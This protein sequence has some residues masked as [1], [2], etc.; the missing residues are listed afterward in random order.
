MVINIIIYNLL[1]VVAINNK[2]TISYYP[3]A[4]V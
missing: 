4:T 3:Y 1:L 2:L